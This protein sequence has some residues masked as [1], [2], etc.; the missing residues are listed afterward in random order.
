MFH[1]EQA[2]RQFN[3]MYKMPVNDV[4]TL[5]PT[6]E[7]MSER[8]IKFKSILKK[9][10]NE[11]DA[12]ILEARATEDIGK[13]DDGTKVLLLT[14]LADLLGDIQVFCASEMLKFGLPL[15]KTLHLIMMSNFSKLNPDGS[16][17]FDE[18]GKLQKGPNYWKP[19]PY[20]QKMLQDHIADHARTQSMPAVG[21]VAS[22][23]KDNLVEPQ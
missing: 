13:Q 17:T 7:P 16:A 3:A 4:P 12:I 14:D 20:I 8:L 6:N 1:L 19:E 15:D 21:P 2:I 23:A 9:E 22:P 18:E 11:I 10:L 5:T